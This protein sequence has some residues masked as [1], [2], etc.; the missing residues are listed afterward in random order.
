MHIAPSQRRYAQA[1]LPILLAAQLLA[2]NPE[3]HSNFL[4]R[5]PEESTARSCLSARTHRSMKT[6][7][8]QTSLGETQRQSIFSKSDLRRPTAGS[9][10]DA[11]FTWTGSRSRGVSYWGHA[12]NRTREILQREI[13]PG[14]DF[15]LTEVVHCSK[16]RKETWSSRGFELMCRTLPPTSAFPSLLLGF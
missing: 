8:T 15:A 13:K 14:I 16:S 7:S 6:K 2:C 12:R 1:T 4:S 5:G 3:V 9:L 11:H 10:M